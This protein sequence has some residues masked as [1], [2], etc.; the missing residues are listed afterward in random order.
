MFSLLLFHKE[1]GR[2][3]NLPWF[4]CTCVFVWWVAVVGWWVY[5][6]RCMPSHVSALSS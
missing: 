5:W 1:R 2:I 3:M 6:C 4:V